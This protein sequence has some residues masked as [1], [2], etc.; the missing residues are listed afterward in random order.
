MA[1]SVIAKIQTEKKTKKTIGKDIKTLV[2]SW[3]SVTKERNF[4]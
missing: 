1:L 4:S 3:Y 2:S